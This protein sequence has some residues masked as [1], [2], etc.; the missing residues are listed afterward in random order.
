MN[1]ELLENRIKE[2]ESAI[3]KTNGIIDQQLSNLNML[4]GG[5]QECLFW[6][7]KINQENK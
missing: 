1:K 2:L 7:G 3:V 5:K 6:L 4:N